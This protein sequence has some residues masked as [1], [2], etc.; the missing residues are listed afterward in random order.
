[1][2]ALAFPD[3]AARHRAPGDQ[4]QPEQTPAGLP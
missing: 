1:V 4:E 2:G 3:A